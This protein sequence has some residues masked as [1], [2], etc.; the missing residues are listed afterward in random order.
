MGRSHTFAPGEWYHCYNRGVEKRKTYL[1]TADF[2]RFKVLM[3]MSNATVSPINSRLRPAPL[4]ELI[5]ETARRGDRLVNIGAYALMPNHF[6]LVLQEKEEGGISRFMQKLLT[7]YTMYF[8]KRYERNGPLFAGVFKS[9]H[10]G[11]DR[12]FKHLIS[13]VHLNPVPLI[14][15]LWKSGR[16]DIERVQQ[17]L[18]DYR[19]SSLPDFMDTSNRPDKA[20]LSAEIFDAYNVPPLNKMVKDAHEYYQD[21]TTELPY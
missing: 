9:R 6:H 21:H 16:A 18:L 3:Y 15:P 20:I 19:H 4:A 17:T 11:D 7:G 13:Y 14:D 1:D 8:N 12:Y 5:A 2:S 10:V